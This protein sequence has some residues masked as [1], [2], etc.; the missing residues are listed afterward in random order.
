MKS[1]EAP[2][3]R[4]IE[5]VDAGACMVYREDQS[6]NREKLA[7]SGAVEQHLAKYV[8]RSAPARTVRGSVSC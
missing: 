7:K 1:G 5:G 6:D 8:D 2:A 4:I 3:T